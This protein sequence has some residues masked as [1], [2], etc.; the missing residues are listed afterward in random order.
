MGKNSAYKLNPVVFWPVAAIMVIILAVSFI[1]QKAFSKGVSAVLNAE[2]VNLK[3]LIGPVVLFLIVTSIV[4]MVHPFGKT[5]IGGPDARPKFSNFSY[6][7]L[8]ICSTIAIGIVFWGVA[9]PMNYFEQPWPNWGVDAESPEAAVRAIAET[10]LEWA[11]GQYVLYGTF[12]MAMGLAIYNF[13]QPI[14]TSSFL[15]LLNGKP[16]K[17]WV[18]TLVDIVCLIGIVAGVTCSLGTGT[19]QM[20]SGLHSIFGIE[21]NNVVWLFV[22]LAVVAGFL[23]MSVGGIAKGIKIVTDQNLRLYYIIM[24]IMLIIGPTVYILDMYTESTGYLLNHFIENIC[25]TGG[26]DGNSEPI[27]WMIWLFVS[28][29]AFAPIVG[30]F[31]AQVS[32]GRTLKEM[33]IGNWIMPALVNSAWFC[34]FGAMAFKK[35]TGGAFDIWGAIQSMGMESAMFSFFKSLPAGIVFCVVFW[36][37]IYLSFVTLASS[38]TTTAAVTSMNQIRKLREGE[39]APLWMKCIWAAIMAISAYAFIT[40]AGIDGAKSAALIGGMPSWILLAIAGF[41]LWR[42]MNKE[43]YEQY[44]EN[45]LK[46]AQFEDVDG[47]ETLETVEG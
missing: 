28:A 40:V 26:I 16:A 32:Y 5:R 37:I 3:F 6:W 15:Y 47:M 25:Y 23:L 29:V 41:C 14:R 11:W 13:K 44:L 1:N 30:L 38:A 35:Q 7:G 31:I 21:I 20:S 33:V 36:I 10:N 27:M 18:N 22:E 45:A 39:E 2:V 43:R 42:V 24:I 9:E 8:C 4:L 34:I 46:N 12:A 17:P 19:M